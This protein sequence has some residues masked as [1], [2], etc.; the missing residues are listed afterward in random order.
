M[1]G[2]GTVGRVQVEEKSGEVKK[3][4]EVKLERGQLEKKCGGES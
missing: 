4:N 1:D 3:R 2:Y